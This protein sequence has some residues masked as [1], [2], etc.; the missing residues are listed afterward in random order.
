[1]SA[2]DVKLTVLEVWTIREALGGFLDVA[3]RDR[4][5]MRSGSALHRQASQSIF[6]IETL[7]AKLPPVELCDACLSDLAAEQDEAADDKL[8]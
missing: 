8:H 1:M 5:G 3:R 2:A 4:R 7:L 6:V